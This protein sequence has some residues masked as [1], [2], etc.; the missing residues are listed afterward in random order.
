MG[1][2]RLDKAEGRDVSSPHAAGATRTGERGLAFH[3][4][5]SVLKEEAH[6]AAHPLTALA[7]VARRVV[8][9]G[10]VTPPASA[11]APP[12]WK[13]GQPANMAD[14][15]LAPI[16]QPPSPKAPGEI[17]LA[18]IKL[19]PGFKAELWAH[20]INNARAMTW[21]D[22][23]TLFVSSR[24]AG[25]VYAV[26]DKGGQREVKVIAKGLNLPN[27]VA[28]KDGT[29]YV[30]EIQ[31]PFPRV[32]TAGKRRATPGASI[33]RRFGFAGLTGLGHERQAACIDTGV[34]GARRVSPAESAGRAC[35]A[36]P[37]KMRIR[38]ATLNVWALPAPLAPSVRARM[39]AIGR[40]LASARSRRDR[41]PGG[42]DRGRARALDR[43]RPRRRPPARLAPPGAASAA[44]S[45]C[46]R[47]C[48][49]DP[50][51]ST[52]SRCAAIRRGRITRITTAARAGRRSSSRPARVRCCSSTPICTPATR[53]TSRTPTARIAS[54]RS[55][56]SRSHRASCSIQS[57]CWE[58]ST[59]RTINPSTRSSP[60]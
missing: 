53:R 10:L 5:S 24:V 42:L 32:P 34:E 28:F 6:H 17:P 19:P 14:S 22:K 15:A 2:G 18:K 59:S 23:G 16:A 40:Q 58:T 1:M 45:W 9:V 20:G 38:V 55:R 13:Q 60:G 30:A 41:L 39:Q 29:L 33:G 47:A 35:A 37:S 56:S 11:Q 21:G 27:G 12:T 48:R 8:G 4:G 57:S 36:G 50:R 31:F 46:S 3:R 49:S 44:D 25:N 26:V 54:V 52:R 43:R 51:A 7:L